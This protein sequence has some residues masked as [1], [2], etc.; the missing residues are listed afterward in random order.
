VVTADNI[1]VVPHRPGPLLP[2]ETSNNR[3][4]PD[5]LDA[6]VDSLFPEVEERAGWVDATLAIGG[7]GLLAWAWIGSAPTIVTVLGIGALALGC[8]L[9]LRAA[10]RRA[11]R[12]SERRRRET[13]MRQG[14]PL[15]ISSPRTA[16]LTATYD[17]LLGLEQRS[18]RGFDDPGIAAAHSALL[19]VASLLNG[20]APTSDRQLDYIDRRAA[21]LNDLL[22]A[23]QEI[24]ATTD[25]ERDDDAPA[26]HP[27]ALV[28]ARE[29]LDQI[30]PLNAVTRLEE[31]IAE[32]KAR[33][34]DR[35]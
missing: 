29:E 19:E 21:A 34:R 14:V 20:R 31:L 25:A 16:A 22:A 8:I 11:R 27:D 17:A 10:W 18:G 3:R 2:L 30:A 9:P 6:L 5:D 28:D 7:A 1:V 15:D 33:Q 23:L 24:E 32:A 26:L 13:L 4:G 12:R 35:D